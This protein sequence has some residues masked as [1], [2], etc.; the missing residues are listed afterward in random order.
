MSTSVIVVLIIFQALFVQVWFV[1]FLRKAFII[2]LRTRYE[3]TYLAS[4][5]MSLEHLVERSNLL[6]QYREELRKFMRKLLTT[7]LIVNALITL[8]II[9]LLVR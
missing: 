1:N 9:Y 8:T 4:P 3:K 7:S 5:T 6:D 2:M